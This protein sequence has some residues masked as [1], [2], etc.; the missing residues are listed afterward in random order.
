LSRLGKEDTMELV[1]IF[2]SKGYKIFLKGAPEV[3]LK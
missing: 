3:I 1:V 2:P